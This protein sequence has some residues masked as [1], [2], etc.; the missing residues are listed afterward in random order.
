MGELG[1]GQ[2]SVIR[3]AKVVGLNLFESFETVEVG[4][5]GV[6]TR[7]GIWDESCKSWWFYLMNHLKSFKTL[8]GG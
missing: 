4:E 2:G 1:Q 8:K 6:W 3:D 7:T 5:L